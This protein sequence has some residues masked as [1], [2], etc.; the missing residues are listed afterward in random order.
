VV[1]SRAPVA[2]RTQIG[3]RIAA[4]AAACAA[5]A[6]APAGAAE[7]VEAGS[8]PASVD[9]DPWRLVFTDAGILR[10]DLCGPS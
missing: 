2:E 5:L 6:P 1:R 9:A 4:V 3:R 7:V 8:L 10:V